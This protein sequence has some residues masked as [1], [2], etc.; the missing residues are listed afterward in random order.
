M[1]T[2]VV[3]LTDDDLAHLKA[4]V[5]DALPRT[6][7]AT[8]CPPSLLDVDASLDCR[9]CLV[10]IR[11]NRHDVAVCCTQCGGPLVL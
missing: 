10:R 2:N 7:L 6:D 8:D 11:F 3:L 5:G 4:L 9:R 1:F